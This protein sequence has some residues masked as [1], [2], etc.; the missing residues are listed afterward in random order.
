MTPLNAVTKPFINQL[1][2]FNEYTESQKSQSNQ[3]SFLNQSNSVNQKQNS[4]NSGMVSS[5][6]NKHRKSNNELNR[7]GQMEGISEDG[8]NET[9]RSGS[10]N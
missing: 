8:I 2:S 1:K 3:N 5:V 10:E 9:H 4:K 7:E 6:G